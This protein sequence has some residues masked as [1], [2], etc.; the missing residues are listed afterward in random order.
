[1]NATSGSSPIVADTADVEPTLSVVIPVFNE[2]ATL[3]ELIARVRAVPIDK[4]ILAVDDGSTDGSFE[5]LTRLAENSTDLRIVKHP[6]NR[7]KGA[8]VRTALAQVRGQVVVIQ[9][10]DLE[11]D[12]ADY[13]VLIGPILAG[14]ADVVYGSRFIS[15]APRRV[16]YFW[17]YAAN[18]MLTLLS[19]ALTGLNLSD[20]ETCYKAV[21]RDVAQALLPLLK[22]DGFGFDPELTAKIARGRFR[23]YEVGISY[24]G[25]T[26]AEG[27]KIG[28]L[29][30]LRIVWAIFRYAAAD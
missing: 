6:F 9:D 16:L 17:H 12:P 3:A 14:R 2:A 1:M 4:E 11:Y 24:H 30:G 23:V 13:P 26:Y 28:F 8:A 7:G 19:D 25:R 22:E 20:I 15:A 29:D 27:K 18:R 5:I 21:R 10:A